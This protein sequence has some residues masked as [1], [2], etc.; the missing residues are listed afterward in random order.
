M[1]PFEATFVVEAL[2]AYG[3]V[4]RVYVVAQNMKTLALAP[5]PAVS[6][7]LI[8][9]LCALGCESCKL[10]GPGLCDRCSAGMRRDQ[11]GLCKPC[12]DHCTRC[13]L[14]DDHPRLSI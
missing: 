10:A 3:F 9:S 7:T 2:K 4:Y 11:W 14:D 13:D 6:N 1:M 5:Q 8:T 12:P